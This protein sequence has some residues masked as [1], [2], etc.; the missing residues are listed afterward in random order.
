MITLL[1]Q[2]ADTPDGNPV[3]L[4]IPVALVVVCVIGVKAL[5]NVKVGVVEA[6]PVAQGAV[7]VIV[8]VAFTQ[9]HPPLN[10]ILY[11]KV[12]DEL[13]VP[14]IVILL[15]DHEAVTP[16]GNPVAVPIPVALVVLCVIGVKPVF[17]ISVG[18]EVAPPTVLVGTLP[19]TGEPEDIFKE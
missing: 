6:A 12:P 2:A 11:E 3:A 8:P 13:G 4:P 1:T 17:T 9:P 16:E 7:T 15:A 14:L 5:F 10:G 19:Q 18:A